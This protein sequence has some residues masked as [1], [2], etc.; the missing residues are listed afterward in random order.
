MSVITAES[1]V[2]PGEVIVPRGK[3]RFWD[4]EAPLAYLF[5]VPGL[6]LLVLFMAYPFFLGI[7]LSMTDKMV[8]FADFDFIGLDNYRDLV[9]YDPV[10]KATEAEAEHGASPGRWRLE[11]CEHQHSFSGD[12]VSTEKSPRSALRA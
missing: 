4:R 11:A 12:W 6:A 2:K 7:Y 5:M 3:A 8:G 9:Q 10:G 1:S